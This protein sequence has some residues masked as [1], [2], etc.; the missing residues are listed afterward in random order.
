MGHP[1]LTPPGRTARHT[2]AMRRYFIPLAFLS[3]SLFVSAKSYYLHTFEKIQLTDQFWCE[4]AN[5]G[6]FNRDGKSDVVSGPFWYQGPDFKTRHEFY[7]ATE[8]FKLKKPD[9]SEQEI[10]G[11]EG[12]LGVNN[13]YSKNF[14][15]YSHDFN[16]DKWPDILVLGFPGEQSWWF[17]NPQGKPGHWP[18]H[19]ALD[20][21]DNESPTFG[22]LTGD[23]KPEIICS[24]KGAL[25]YAEPDPKNPTAPWKW[26]NISPDNKYHR[27]THGLGFGDVNGDR[28]L[29]IL[30][31]D[32]WWEQPSSL[33]GDPMW[34]Q[35]KYPFA[36]GM[37]GAQMYAYD[38]NGDGLNDV[39]TSFAA[40]AYGL[41]WHEQLPEKNNG[42]ISFR[43]HIILN[44]QAPPNKYGITFSQ[45]HAVDL[46][47]MDGDGL[48]D[49]VTGKRFWAHGSN[50]DPDPNGPAVVYWFKLTRNKDKSVDFVPFQI[51]NNSG[52]GTQVV[53]HD[54]NSD[55]QP[56]IVVGNKKGT[57]VHVHKATKVSK[58]EW[59]AAQPKPIAKTTRQ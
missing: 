57:F 37:G 13:T 34:T 6:D 23:G 36:P 35:H 53:A 27:F 51:D 3:T 26:H 2:V 9:G 25:G 24:S 19:V 18:R 42:K 21:T 44:K 38:V 20:V 10:P 33:A 1:G 11:F 49:I 14:V 39:I 15:A 56:D 58:K 30:E 17:E 16:G 32:G 12:A 5:F 4:G 28:R 45:L 48:K 54:F 31:R 41:S 59:E 22:D 29:D 7:P 52:I 55:K 43:E 40:H 46:V 47:D 8:K 50:G